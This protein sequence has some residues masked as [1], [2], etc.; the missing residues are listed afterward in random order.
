VHSIEGD[1]VPKP[2]DS[3]SYKRFPIPP[4]RLT[5]SAVHVQIVRLNR[6]VVHEKWVQ[7]EDEQETPPSDS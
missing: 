2:G 7:K 3:V 5:F 6:E 4:K 1:F